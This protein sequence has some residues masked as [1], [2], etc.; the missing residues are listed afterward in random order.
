MPLTKEPA[1]DPKTVDTVVLNASNNAA[2]NTFKVTA[3]FQ[4]KNAAGAAIKSVPVDLLAHLTAAQ[5]TTLKN[6]LG[7]LRT[8][9]Q[10][11]IIP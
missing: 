10:A 4:L 6:F 8:K 5:I 2:D 7:A 3:T 11:E 9:A 1:N